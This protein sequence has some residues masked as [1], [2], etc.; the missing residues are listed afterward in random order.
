M[1]RGAF[2]RFDHDHDFESQQG[3]TL[4]TD[5]LAYTSLLGFLGRLADVVFL[6][7]Y[8]RLIIERRAMAIKAAA[9]DQ[10]RTNGPRRE[11]KL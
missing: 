7:S 1:V 6:E 2:S 4:M 3:S 8:M 10:S 9:E 11:Q 5:R